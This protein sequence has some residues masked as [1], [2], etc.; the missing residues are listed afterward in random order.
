MNK[1][2][3]LI[4]AH[5]CDLTFYTLLSMVDHPGNDVYIHMDVN[6]EAFEPETVRKQMQYSH[7]YFAPRIHVVWGAFSLTYVKILLLET[8]RAT[9]NSY[10]YYHFLSG[11]DLPIQTQ[12][13]IH[14]F[15]AEHRGKEFVH[16]EWPD[17][18]YQDRVRYYYFFQEQAGRGRSLQKWI[19]RGLDRVSVAVQ[20]LLR[21]WRNPQVPFQKGE[22]WASITQ[23]F[24]DHILEQWPLHQDW[25]RYTL[26]SDEALF[27]TFADASSFK[28]RLYRPAG[29]DGCTA[30]MRLI[31]WNRGEP[32]V[33]RL[34]DWE[35]LQ[36]SPMLWARKFD[37]RVDSEI[38]RKLQEA[39]SLK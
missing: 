38:I 1:H 39:Y 22:G 19:F 4:T 11:E 12:E 28:E 18:P 8:A 24:A 13:T 7:V 32:Y 2:A 3:Y 34:S 31:D 36:Q 27:Q 25:F 17:F 9:G 37:A 26:Y 6:N 29:V 20:K 33:F 23:A 5:K 16:Y 35:Q 21:V 10:E 15:F 30:M 14:A